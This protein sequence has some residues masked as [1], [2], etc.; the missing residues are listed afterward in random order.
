[1]AEEPGFT[2]MGLSL[3]SIVHHTKGLGN[4]QFTPGKAKIERYK[5][6]ACY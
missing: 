4:L 5:N 3:G 1:M 6:D 2:A